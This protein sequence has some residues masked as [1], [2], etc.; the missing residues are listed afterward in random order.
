MIHE[1]SGFPA[2][3]A[4]SALDV[5]QA[6]KEKFRNFFLPSVFLPSYRE[7]EGMETALDP[8]GREWRTQASFLSLGLET[9]RIVLAK[10][11]L[12]PAPL[13]SR[14]NEPTRERLCWASGPQVGGS[15]HAGCGSLRAR[16]A[17]LPHRGASPDA[18]K[19]PKQG[20]AASLRGLPRPQDPSQT[21]SLRQLAGGA[22]GSGASLGLLGS[23]PAL[24]AGPGLL[25]AKMSEVAGAT[26]SPKAFEKEPASSLRM[27]KDQWGLASPQDRRPCFGQDPAIVRARGKMARGTCR[28][29]HPHPSVSVL[30]SS[31]PPG[32]NKMGGREPRLFRLLTDPTVGCWKCRR[33]K[34]ERRGRTQT[35]PDLNVVGWGRGRLR[36][37]GCKCLVGFLFARRAW[38]VR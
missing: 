37:P 2:R 29:P 27:S 32:S 14:M 7:E 12:S 24:P 3:R 21:P 4:V 34:W 18:E 19:T 11:Q 28:P 8:T 26:A 17:P 13:T 38:K 20:S 16:Q 25:P 9:H 22:A 23:C 35:Q 5:L 36:V 15:C 30:L 6:R 1:A 10:G 31:S 33:T